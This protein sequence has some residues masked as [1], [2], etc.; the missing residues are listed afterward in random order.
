M[1]AWRVKYLLPLLVHDSLCRFNK[2]LELNFKHPTACPCRYAK[3]AGVHDTLMKEWTMDEPHGAL[4]ELVCSVIAHY[5]VNL[6][7]TLVL[8][9]PTGR[10]NGS[11][12][13]GPKAW[14]WIGEMEEIASAFS[15]RALVP[16]HLRPAVV[17]S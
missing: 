9:A 2:Q 10:T 4:G 14:R 6:G 13:I 15:V 17:S 1:R 11:K 5:S 8:R 16:S 7:M 3:A 12:G